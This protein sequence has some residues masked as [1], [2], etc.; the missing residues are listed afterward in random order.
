M[1]QWKRFSEVGRKA[2][3][4]ARLAVKE[5][6]EELK[7]NGYPIARYDLELRKPYLE[8]PDGRREYSVASLETDD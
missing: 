5:E 7:R 2:E 6:L 3:M 4:L 8:Y 1:E